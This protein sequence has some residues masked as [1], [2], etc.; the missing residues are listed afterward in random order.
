[1]LRQERCLF[2][3]FKHGA[4]TNFRRA[5]RLKTTASDTPVRATKKI[6]PGR[7]MVF[8][9]QQ[10]EL[11]QSDARETD[12]PDPTADLSLNYALEL[13]NFAAIPDDDQQPKEEEPLPE[14]YPREPRPVRPVRVLLQSSSRACTRS[15]HLERQLALPAYV[16]N[17]NASQSND[18]LSAVLLQDQ[19]VPLGEKLHNRLYQR[20]RHHQRRQ[21]RTPATVSSSR[22]LSS[23]AA[24]V[25]Y[26]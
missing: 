18:R 6:G 8:K 13:A 19:L 20:C 4:A 2:T 7:L 22:T 14:H 16:K 5:P 24:V 23:G 12:A 9:R 1:M 3:F 11:E 15:L 25:L 10:V 17:N 21:L 26:T